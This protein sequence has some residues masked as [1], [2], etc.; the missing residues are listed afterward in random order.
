MD[1]KQIVAANGYFFIIVFISL[2]LAVVGLAIY[3]GL[4]NLFDAP[5]RIDEFVERVEAG[6]DEYGVE[7][8]HEMCQNEKGVLAQLF[9]TAM[10]H[11]NRGKV[12]ARDAMANKI[13]QDVLPSLTTGMPWILFV[14]KVAPM[15][16][17]LG[18]VWGMIAAFGKIAG[19]TQVEPSAL[20]NSI[21]MALYTTLEGLFIAIFAL[22]FYT[23]FRQQVQRYEVELQK[24]AQAALDLLPRF[25]TQ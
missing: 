24:A 22:T 9:V 11:A 3:R 15:L 5:G 1:L 10:E 17:L 14:S 4:R 12:A 20:A 16:G 2:S 6:I 7:A 13:Q 21:G 19:A 8:T 23:I 18:T 25:R